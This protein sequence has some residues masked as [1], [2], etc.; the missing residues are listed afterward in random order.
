MRMLSVVLGLGLVIEMAMVD[1][2]TTSRFLLVSPFVQYGLTGL[3]VGW[4]V[5]Y[6]R[7][8]RPVAV[9]ASSP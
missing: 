3:L 7:R 8:H 9:T 5:L 6:L 4:A 2:M 1:A